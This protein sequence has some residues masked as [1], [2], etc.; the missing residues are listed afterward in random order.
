MPDVNKV[1]DKSVR[2]ILNEQKRFI[3][4]FRNSI[5]RRRQLLEPLSRC[6]STV[7]KLGT[8]NKRAALAQKLAH[9]EI[10]VKSHH[11]E[12]YEPHPSGPEPSIADTQERVSPK[13]ASPVRLP[14]IIVPE[15]SDVTKAKVGHDIA[16]IMLT[17]HTKRRVER[18]LETL[19]P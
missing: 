4:D 5:E 6:N 15:N 9:T 16:R 7:R 1:K 3:I 8:V 11:V 18:W 12:T 14:V 10:V 17:P 13:R 2:Q 19:P